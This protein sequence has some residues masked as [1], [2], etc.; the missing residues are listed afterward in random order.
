MSL[1]DWEVIW[2]RQTP[3]VGAHADLE[4]L[5]QTFEARRRKLASGLLVRDVSEASAGI[6]VSLVLTWVWWKMGRSA[7]PMGISIAICLGVS[8]LFIKERF[9]IRQRRVGLD[10]PLI[11]KLDHEIAELRHQRQFLRNLWKW[12]LAPIFVAWAVA[13]ATMGTLI[14]R[15]APPSMLADLMKNPVTASVII[16]YFAVIVPLVFLGSHFN[17]KK[18][19]IKGTDPRLE[20]L[21]KLRRNILSNN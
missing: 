20:E 4:A 8:A 1:S 17:I 6:L 16:L 3:P 2:K 18:G 12:Y 19:V 7:W 14:G 9:Q 5:K 13:I 10:A 15:R 11:A 21:E